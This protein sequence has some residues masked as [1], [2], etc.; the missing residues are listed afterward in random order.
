MVQVGD[1]R[2]AGIV[3]DVEHTVVVDVVGAGR[4]ADPRRTGHRQLARVERDLVGQLG[5]VPH[6]PAVHHGDDGVGPAG[7]DLPRVV[8]SG[9]LHA[10]QLLGVVRDGRVVVAVTRLGRVVR[11]LGAVLAVERLGQVGGRRLRPGAVAV[12][13]VQAG[14]VVRIAA[15]VRVRHAT[16]GQSACAED[17]GK[18][19][20][21]QQRLQQH[22]G[23]AERRLLVAN[24]HVSQG[25]EIHQL[26]KAPQLAQI[27]RPPTF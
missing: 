8:G 24:F 5:R 10:E 22:P 12:G 20:H 2:V 27:E 6:D 17:D 3:E 1:A 21:R 25:Q 15:G 13:Y 7:R 11:E 23:D 26:S 14:V 18:N 16:R 9:P 19:A 4:A